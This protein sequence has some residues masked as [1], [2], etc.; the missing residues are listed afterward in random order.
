MRRRTAFFLLL[1]LV[2]LAGCSPARDL[3]GTAAPGYVGDAAAR[4]AAADWSRTETVDVALSEYAFT[5]A[6]LTF[7]A[8]TAYRLRLRNTGTA[9]HFF[10]SDGF[11]KA[12]AV[13]RLKTAGGEVKATYLRSIV[14]PPGAVK[15]LTFVAVRPGTYRLECTAPFHAAFGMVGRLRVR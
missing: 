12:I 4:V 2:A 9:T 1:V 14:L 7:R 15:E 13:R 11:F 6:E 5:P 3:Y 10:V 8:G